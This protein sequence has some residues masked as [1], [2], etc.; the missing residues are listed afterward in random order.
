MDISSSWCRGRKWEECMWEWWILSLTVAGTEV[1]VSESTVFAQAADDDGD[2][3]EEEDQTYNDPRH[4]Q[5]RHQQR[6]LP[7]R[8]PLAPA[9]WVLPMALVGAHCRDTEGDAGQARLCFAVCRNGKIFFF[10]YSLL[11]NF[12]EITDLS[13]LSKMFLV[14]TCHLIFKYWQNMQKKNNIV[15]PVK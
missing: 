9:V 11:R 7:S 13:E 3:G 5:R 12:T 1:W 15:S 2:A 6:R 10:P 14:Y 8:L 4:H